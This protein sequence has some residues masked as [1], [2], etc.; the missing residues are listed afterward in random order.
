MT[1]L[2][3]NGHENL[4]RYGIKCLMHRREGANIVV[5]NSPSNN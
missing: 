5:V 2:R 1:L 4:K 3:E